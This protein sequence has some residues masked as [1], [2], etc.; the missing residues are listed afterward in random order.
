MI[1]LIPTQKP[2]T[3]LVR[4]FAEG[5]LAIPEIQRDV[6]WKPDQVKQLI[7]SIFAQYP[8]GSLIFWE[9][10]ERDATLV[11]SMIR[12]ER[13]KQYEGKLPKYFLLD[14]Q[15][16]LTALASVLLPRQRLKEVLAEIEEDMPYIFCNLKR[17][18]DELEATND[19]SG[20]TFPWFSVQELLDG[21]LNQ[22]EDVRTRL[23]DSK[24][25]N[26]VMQAQQLC[27]YQFPVQIIQDRQYT[28]VA[29]IFA[30][31]NSLGT[32]LTGAEIH[33]AR[34][35][36]YWKGITTDFRKYRRELRD[37]KFD[38]DLSFLMRAITSVECHTAQI[39][40]LTQRMAKN[41]VTPKHLKRSWHRARQAIDRV[42]AILESELRLDRAR[43]LPSKNA[44][45]PLV[46]YMTQDKSKTKATRQMLRFFI[47]SQLSERYGGGAESVFRTDFRVLTDQN[48]TPRQNLEDLAKA[49]AADARQY[50]RG[51]KIRPDDVSGLPA[52]NVMLLLIYVLMRRQEATDWGA[53]GRTLLKDIEPADMHVHHIFPFNFM[54][55]DKDAHAYA[56]GEEL[57]PS[58][59]RTQVNDI[60]NMTF[61]R[62]STNNRI[63]DLPPW[64][65]LPQETTKEIRRAHF[66]PEDRSLWTP[67][68]FGDFLEAR[69]ALIA[70][71][72]TRLLKSFR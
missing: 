46:Y 24:F 16:R 33:L 21:N 71:A 25:K 34:L 64:Q 5:D 63:G 49:A 7:G 45:I 30:R 26:I 41:H 38:L 68:R 27:N 47:F 62:Y 32:P 39:A 31:V 58:E 67:E 54:V 42:L 55:K 10:R 11:R 9:P 1:R 66:I 17:F 50:Y 48:D 53:E 22:R 65:Y 19:C 44:L 61:L 52:K 29:E 20:Y 6:V 70:K 69:R 13:L 2:V 18:P 59:F 51:L 60:A 14:G 57:N 56:D 35:V 36:P 37:R 8:C 28:D 12:P 23:G 43:Y 3:D 72:A 4:E 40:K 15:Q